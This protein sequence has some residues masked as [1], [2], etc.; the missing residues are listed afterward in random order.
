MP[1][2]IGERKDRSRVFRMQVLENKKVEIDNFQNKD[3]AL[4]IINE[5]I[6]YYKDSF[7]G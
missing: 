3:D 2:Y 6:V 4:K 5:A 1:F 7:K